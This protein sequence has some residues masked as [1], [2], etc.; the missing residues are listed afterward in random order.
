MYVQEET[1]NV[2]CSDILNML[3]HR[4]G[5]FIFCLFSQMMYILS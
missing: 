5:H 2:I 3:I 4:T 1:D